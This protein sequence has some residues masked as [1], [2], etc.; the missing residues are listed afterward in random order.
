MESLLATVASAFPW[1]KTV[2][3]YRLYEYRVLPAPRN[4]I[5]VTVVDV[6]ENFPVTNALFDCDP[7]PGEHAFLPLPTLGVAVAAFHQIEQAR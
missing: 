1:K 3:N 5:P 6:C 2:R 4:P 7:P